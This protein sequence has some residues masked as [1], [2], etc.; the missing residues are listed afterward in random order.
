MKTVS[1]NNYDDDDKQEYY[2][3]HYHYYNTFHNNNLRIMQ[4][5]IFL[6]IRFDALCFSWNQTKEEGIC[7]REPDTHTKDL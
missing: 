1:T 2:H 5:T 3:L 4:R 6:T 7:L